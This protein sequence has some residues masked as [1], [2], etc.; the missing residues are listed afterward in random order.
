MTC[1]SFDCCVIRVSQSFDT[2]ALG[3]C[4][5]RPVRG[6]PV[7][8]EAEQGPSR[9]ALRDATN[10]FFQKYGVA[11]V[12]VASVVGSG[13]IFIASSAGVQYGYALI[14]AFV[15][16]ALLGIMAQDMSARLGIFG[17]PLG[18]FM[19]R[20]L[21]GR[22]SMVVAAV[23]SVGA[24]LWTIELTAATAKGI[25]VLLNGAIGWQVLSIPIVILAILTG[26]LNYKRLEQVLTAT[27]FVLLAAY[28]VV[29]GVSTPPPVE[30]ACGVIPSIPAPAALTLAASILGSTAIWSNFFLESNLVEEKGWTSAEDIPLM[31]KDLL[32]GYSLAMVLIVSVLVVTATVIGG[33]SG[34]ESF[35]TPALALTRP[36]GQWAAVLFLFGT[37]AAAFNSIIPIMWVPAYLFEHARGKDADSADR[38]FK[39]IYVAGTALG[40][41]APVIAATTRLGVIDMVV[42]FP[43]YNGIVSLPITAVLLFW[44]LN[45][46]EVMGDRVNDLKLNAL[47]V[48][49]V[50]LAFGLAA[51]S[52]PS[53]VRTLTSGGL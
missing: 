22:L 14:W 1:R 28:L 18:A 3:H 35:I 52:L 47:N 23:I 42:L 33:R 17:E 40:I 36:I 41:L 21:G 5:S 27:L 53:L 49:L 9:E 37:A 44:A 34:L 30:V 2:I 10:G 4:W 16:A 26:L 12:M 32:F 15:G 19:H 51:I 6:V 25:E 7:M 20:K 31:R 43:A 24:V 46:E 38:S 39:T 50:I 13:S 11:F 45:D 48:L 29:A 8:A